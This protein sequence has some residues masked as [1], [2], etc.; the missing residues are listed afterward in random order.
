MSENPEAQPNL[1]EPPAAPQPDEQDDT[2]S[3]PGMDWRIVVIIGLAALLL[4][5]AYVNKKYFGKNQTPQTPPVAQPAPAGQQAQTDEPQQRLTPQQMHVRMIAQQQMITMQSLFVT[6]THAYILG[7]PATPVRNPEKPEQILRIQPARLFDISNIPQDLPPQKL[8]RRPGIALRG[9]LYADNLVALGANPNVKMLFQSAEEVTQELLPDDTRVAGIV[10]QEQARAYP[11]KFLLFHDVVNDTLG[12]KPVAVCYSVFAD[13]ATAMLRTLGNGNEQPLVFGTT[14]LMFQ[15]S[16][17]LYDLATESFWW[18]TPR[19]CISGQFLGK[20]LPPVQTHV[21]TWAAWKKLH[22]ETSVLVGTEPSFPVD[23]DKSEYLIP[24]D[25]LTNTMMVFPIYGF[26]FDTAPMRLKEVV[27][28]VTVADGTKPAAKA[29][30]AAFLD[31]LEEGKRNFKDKLGDTEISLAYDKESGLLNAA[32]A[33]GTPLLVQ[34]MFWGAWFGIHQ[35]TEVWREQEL[36]EAL[37]RAN[38]H[39][40]KT[41][42]D[43]KTP[44]PPAPEAG[45]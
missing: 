2:Q 6:R 41:S 32:A 33:D 11:L 44:L 4:I 45:N 37:V 43:D 30:A 21:T 28:G 40:L 20:R 39:V 14:G 8:Q 18:T 7:N 16:N 22:P 9:Y 36:R 35:K 34:R 42:P 5:A 23:Y 38:Q 17:L 25:Y 31:R 13:A 3:Q 1:N 26:N 15:T 24:K 29:Y 19:F 10:V 27:F 12:G